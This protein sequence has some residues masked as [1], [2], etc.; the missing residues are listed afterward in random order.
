MTIELLTLGSC[1]HS[2]FIKINVLNTALFYLGNE[3]RITDSV[4]NNLSLS[5]LSIY[6]LLYKEEITY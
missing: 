3:V 4:M 6:S 5:V 1:Y 2:T